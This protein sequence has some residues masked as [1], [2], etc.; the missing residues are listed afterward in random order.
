VELFPGNYED[1]LWRKQ[2]G[3]E[4]QTAAMENELVCELSARRSSAGPQLASAQEESK[5]TVSPANGDQPKFEQPES[6]SRRLNPIKRKQMQDRLHEVEEEITRVEAAI[7]L[8]ETQLQTFVSTEETQRRTRE[9]GARKGDLEGL[10]Q[11]WE[12]LSEALQA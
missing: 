11:E 8:Y 3:V 7:A 5:P 9:L 10:M 6:K 1:Y 4:R 2:G 12:E